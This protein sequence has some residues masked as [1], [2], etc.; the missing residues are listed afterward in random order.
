MQWLRS[1]DRLCLG[2][3]DIMEGRRAW[4]SSLFE[5]LHHGPIYHIEYSRQLR[6]V[7]RAGGQRPRV[8]RDEEVLF[9]IYPHTMHHPFY[10]QRK[11]RPGGKVGTFLLSYNKATIT[12]T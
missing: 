7:L 3:V 10:L 6:W 2:E 5:R 1:I 11:V 8:L 4:D 12:V 9:S